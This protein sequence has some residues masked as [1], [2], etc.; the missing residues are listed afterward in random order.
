[1]FRYDLHLKADEKRAVY[2]AVKNDCELE[3]LKS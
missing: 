3:L 2:H 1:M